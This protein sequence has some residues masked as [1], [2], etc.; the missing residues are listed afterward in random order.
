MVLMLILA[1][2]LALAIGGAGWKHSRWGYAG[3]SPAAAI[4]V[5]VLVL[6]FSG[7]AHW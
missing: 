3:W 4:L 5:V 7:H 2:L 1:V 6:W